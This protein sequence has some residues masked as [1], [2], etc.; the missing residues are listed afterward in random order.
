VSFAAPDTSL[1]CHTCYETLRA[2]VGELRAEN[3]RLR[4]LA[5]Y[6]TEEGTQMY[7]RDIAEAKTEKMNE[8]AQTIQDI[9]A[10][11]ARYRVEAERLRRACLQVREWGIEL[12]SLQPAER[13]QRFIIL[14]RHINQ[15]LRT[16]VKP[17]EQPG[18]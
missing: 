16:A 13:E 4:E 11:A 5:I 8:W 14:W 15:T 1:H 7:W 12:A 18:F 9:N 3:E 2:E 6:S 17:D 10:D